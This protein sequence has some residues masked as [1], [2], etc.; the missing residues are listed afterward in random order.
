LELVIDYCKFFMLKNN[1]R[2]IF[3]PVIFLFIPSFVFAAIGEPND[4]FYN[5][6]KDYFSQIRLQEAWQETTGSSQTVIAIIDSGVDMDH[7][8]IIG[9]MW[10]NRGEIPLNGIDVTIMDM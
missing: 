5:Y 3:L 6:Q 4:E 7:Q 8:D 9:N 2:K 1:K 10:F